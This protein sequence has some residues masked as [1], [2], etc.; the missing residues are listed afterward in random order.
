M[1][2][3]TV[4][5]SHRSAL[6]DLVRGAAV[7]LL[8]VVQTV[9][10][11]LAGSGA[12]GEPVGDV[13]RRYATPLLAADWAFVIWLPIYA[14]FLA[15]A[16]YQLLPDQRSRQVHRETGWWLAASAVFNAGWVPAFAAGWLP[17]AELLIIGLLV[18]LA[19]VF[20]RLTRRPAE[21]V[22]ERVV[23]RGTVAVYTG[24]VSF[25]VVLGTAATGAWVGLPGSGALATIAAVVVLVAVTAVVCWVVLA[26]TAVVG[27]AVA[28][29]WALAGVALNDPPA[30]VVVTGAIAIVA[31]VAATTRRLTTAGNPPRAAWG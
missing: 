3:M 6:S 25:A 13:A 20:G 16:V 19:V 1:G 15:Y 5:S 27:Y 28:T 18:T 31:V 7:V 9:V 21:N 30:A 24:W 11:A 23:L 14:G 10:A 12:A 22:A 8:A 26:G 29:V 2:G 4:A 17:L